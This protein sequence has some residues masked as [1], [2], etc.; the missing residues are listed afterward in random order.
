MRRTNEAGVKLI[1]KWESFVDHVYLC[2]AGVPTIGYGETNPEVIREFRGK[3]MTEEYASEL[4]DKSLVKYENAVYTLVNSH[5]PLTDNEY[6]SLVSFTYNLGANALRNS[7]LRKVIL[8]GE[9]DL[10]PAQFMRWVYAGG[11]KLNG[12]FNRRKEEANLW[13]T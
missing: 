4:L 9:Y 10:A 2:S 12:L 8:R 6:A 13:T 7:T 11:R 1:K 3:T 5:V